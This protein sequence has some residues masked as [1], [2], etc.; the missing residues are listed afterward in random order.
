MLIAETTINPLPLGSI[1][2]GLVGGLALFLFGLDQMSGALKLIA[3]DG[4]K[5]VLARLTTNRFAGA[6]AG[7][8]VTAIV[9]SS[10]VTT[11]LAVGFVSAGLMS[12]TQSVGVIIGANVGTTITA[13]LV[14]FR[15]THY[16][17]A[18]VAIG[19]FML[20]GSKHERVRHYGNMVM[21]VGLIFFGMHLMSEGASPLQTYP[22]FMDAM[23][24]MDNPLMAILLAAVFTALVQSSSATTG[25]V[26]TLAGQGFISLEAGIALVFG[27]NIGTCITAALAA[28]GKTRAA[29]RAVAVHVL[30]NV[31][32][33]AIWFA[34]IPQLAEVVRWM[35]PSSEELAGAARLAA[36]T[37]RQIAN[38]HTVFNIANASL[39]IWFTNPFAWLVQ[40]LVPERLAADVEVAQPKYLDPTLLQTPSL[41][42]DMVR[43][44]LGRL[45]AAALHMMRGALETVVQGSREEINALEDLDNNVDALHAAI[46][47]YLGMLSQETLTDDQSAQLHDY[48]STANYLESIGDMIE[49]NMVDAGRERLRTN[50]RISEPTANVLHALNKKVTWATERAIRAV[51][52]HDQDVAREVAAAKVEIN[53]LTANAEMHL[54]KRLSAEAPHRLAMFRLESEIMEYL[55]RMYYFAKRIAKLIAERAPEDEKT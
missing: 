21:G 12:V 40:R 1:L 26:I 42:L 30:F 49:T 15:I 10:S 2:M 16:A 39:F 20:F 51:V 19:F 14:A 3:G 52:S 11:V 5:L 17:L 13:Q 7:A 38:A 25:L 36:E 6:L 47:T 33:V 32:G 24:R 34:F 18:L 44:E 37:P 8:V 29:V 9:Q 41:A 35:S 45:G 54:V 53:R 43:M 50:L 28:I 48:L 31:A 23:R 22:P 27:A 4:L 55:R 46:V